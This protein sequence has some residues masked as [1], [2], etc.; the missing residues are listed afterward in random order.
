MKILQVVEFITPAKGGL[1][2]AV[3]VTA[4]GLVARGHQV[5]IWTSKFG[6]IPHLPT[7]HIR[8][9]DALPLNGLFVTPGIIWSTIRKLRQFDIV[10]LHAVR[11]FQ[12][13]TVG[14]IARIMNLPYVLSP[15]GTLKANGQKEITKHLY[16]IFAQ[17]NKHLHEATIVAAVSNSEANLCASAGIDQSRIKITLNPVETEATILK[18]ALT[19]GPPIIGY[20]GRLERSKAVDKL[21]DA[22]LYAKSIRS[23]LLLEIAGPDDG[24]L[25]RLQTII[26]RKGLNDSVC[27]RGP[28]YGQQKH[29]FLANCTVFANPCSFE[30][31]G[32]SIFEAI[33]QGC[34]VVVSKESG[35]AALA[36]QSGVARLVDTSDP[37]SFGKAIIDQI[38]LPID[39]RVRGQNF[40][41]STLSTEAYLNRIEDIYSQIHKPPI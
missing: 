35:T 3:L 23:D 16:D 38:N 28:L 9:F 27:F 25:Q 30:V 24:D 41:Q 15:H 5:E 26:E 19:Q 11:S 8:T 33:M 12:S 4:E 22:F 14:A 18:H 10:H 39:L 7:V 6:Q 13:I 37:I 1:A 40:V 21:L 20:L 36:E 32:I 31:F 17:T 29:Q 2:Q 34:P